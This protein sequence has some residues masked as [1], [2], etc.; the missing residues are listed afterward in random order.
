MLSSN[1]SKQSPL[2]LHA[3][4]SSRWTSSLVEYSRPVNFDLQTSDIFSLYH[5]RD[6]RLDP[7]QTELFAVQLCKEGRSLKKTFSFP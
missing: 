4:P 3:K 7:E 2:N 6:A 5:G 1:E